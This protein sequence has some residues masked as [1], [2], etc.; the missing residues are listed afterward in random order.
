MIN[1]GKLTKMEAI[2][3][4][5]LDNITN[6]E[7]EQHKVVAYIREL[8]IRRSQLLSFVGSLTEDML[9]NRGK[10]TLSDKI[11]RMALVVDFRK[12]D[13]GQRIGSKKKKRCRHNNAGYCK[14]GSNCEYLHSD[15]VCQQF[16]VSGKCLE[17]KICPLRHPKDC[18]FW[19]GDTRGCLRGKSCKFSHKIENKGKKIKH[20]EQEERNVNEK[21]LEDKKRTSKV[22][23]IEFEKVDSVI[24][25]ATDKQEQ[26]IP[27]H[28]ESESLNHVLDCQGCGNYHGQYSCNKCCEQFCKDCIIRGNKH[29]GNVCLNCE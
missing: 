1:A 14:M 13:E 25:D 19:L 28:K 15:K 12:S 10:Q 16:M 20:H 2:L 23:N 6:L 18:K 9:T 5:I 3:E 22:E 11:C 21:Q 8:E 4:N 29:S 17:Y 24:D 27:T 7:H 26:I